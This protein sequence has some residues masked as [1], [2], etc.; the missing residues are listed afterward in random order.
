LRDFLSVN[1]EHP[2]QPLSRAR[3]ANAD[4]TGP[5]RT[6]ATTKNERGQGQQR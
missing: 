4:A 1:L 5:G 2:Q 6:I 3:T